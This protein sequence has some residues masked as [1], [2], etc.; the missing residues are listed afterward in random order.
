MSERNTKHTHQKKKKK[1]KLTCR[2]F[3][4]RLQHF[5]VF[6]FLLFS[7][8]I[9]TNNSSLTLPSLCHTHTH[10]KQTPCVRT[11]HSYFYRRGFFPRVKNAFS[12]TKPNI[13][14]HYDKPFLPFFFWGSILLE[15]L[16]WFIATCPL[17]VV[18]HYSD[19]FT[20]HAP[21]QSCRTKN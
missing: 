21:Q 20:V 12:L 5:F 2:E 17:W 4:H 19:F 18:T 11:C 8:L 7:F 16:S 3:V 6:L 10:T 14:F 13:L 1:C 9:L 15:K